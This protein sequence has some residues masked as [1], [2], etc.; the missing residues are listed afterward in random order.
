MSKKS[1]D[2]QVVADE[3]AAEQQSEAA[4]EALTSMFKDGA[5]IEVHP[6]CV[7]DHQKLGWV[8]CV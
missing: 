2:K 8:V 7:A 4:A 6:T 3:A 1:D 5:T